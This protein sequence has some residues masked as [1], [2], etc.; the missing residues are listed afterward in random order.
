MQGHVFRCRHCK[1]IRPKRSKDQRY[2]GRAACQ[3]ARNN[4]W[5]RARYAVDPDYRANQRAGT[6]AWLASQGGSAAYYR[7]YRRRRKEQRQ[8]ESQRKEQ[9]Q[10]ESQRKDQ[11]QQESQRKEQR[12]QESQ[13]KEQRQQESRRKERPQQELQLQELAADVKRATTLAPTS[14]VTENANSN[15]RTAQ[16]AVKS[17]RYS[18]LP[19]GS[20]NSNAILVELSIISC[21]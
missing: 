19:L 20:A 12:Q 15:A 2:C 21:G 10:Q 4:D 3:K 11:R 18:L 14:R 17:G 8:Q 6:D 13:R 7:S 1:E 9:R 16:S 5:R